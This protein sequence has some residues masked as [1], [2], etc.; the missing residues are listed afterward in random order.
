MVAGRLPPAATVAAVAGIEPGAVA[1]LTAP[2]HLID[3]GLTAVAAPIGPPCAFATAATVGLNATGGLAEH[4]L[5]FDENLAAA[6]ATTTAARFIVAGRASAAEAAVREQRATFFD[7][8]LDGDLDCYVLN[9]PVA[10]KTMNN[11]DLATDA[12][13]Q[14]PRGEYESDRLYENTGKGRFVDVTARAGL[15]NRAFGLSVLASDFNG[16][17]YPDLFVGNDFV[18]PDFLYLN[19]GKGHF[20]D[21]ADTWLAHTSNHTMGADYADLDNDGFSDLVSLDMLAAPRERRQRLMNTMILERD[22]QMQ[23]SGYGRQ[24][25]R[26]TLQLNRHNSGFSECGYLAGMYAKS[27]R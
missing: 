11:L 27:T 25:M 6:A 21:V 12:R 14:K 9:H 15:S 19:D 8:D 7:Y 3:V 24:A 4:V 18:M 22:R 5:A 23:Q 20:R 13:S 10:F 26:N 2:K 1:A 17:G 16:D